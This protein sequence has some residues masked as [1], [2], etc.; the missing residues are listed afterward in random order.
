MRVVGRPTSSA[1]EWTKERKSGGVIPVYPPNWLTWLVV[2]SIRT[3]TPSRRA[4]TIAA[5]RTDRS[6]EQ[7]E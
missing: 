1:I 3:M 6:A 2:A 4:W 7:T 5:R